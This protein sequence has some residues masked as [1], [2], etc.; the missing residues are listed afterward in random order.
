[1]LLD[2]FAFALTT[3]EVAALMTRGND[4]PDRFG[5]EHALLKLVYEGRAERI[6]LGSDALWRSAPERKASEPAVAAGAGRA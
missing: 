2:T 4:S 6:A 3:Q 1:M 5:A